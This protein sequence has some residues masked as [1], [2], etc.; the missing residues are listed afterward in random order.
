MWVYYAK[1]I[2]SDVNLHCQK[3]ASLN[4]FRSASKLIQHKDS[5][6]LQVPP[7]NKIHCSNL[8]VPIWQPQKWVFHCP[9]SHV[10]FSD[11][12]PIEPTLTDYESGNFGKR[13][14][15]SSGPTSGI[16]RETWRL[17]PVSIVSKLPGIEAMKFGHLEGVPQRQEMGTYDH[18]NSY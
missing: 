11:I 15:E 7:T 18:H 17:I 3:T 16:S 5:Q 12:F 1:L 8:R 9:H 13:F 10:R 4:N 6:G 14:R 2:E